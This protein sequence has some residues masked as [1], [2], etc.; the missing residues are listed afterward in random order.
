M[1]FGHGRGWRTITSERAGSSPSAD[2]APSL[3]SVQKRDHFR[4]WEG[5]NR[6][7]EFVDRG[8]CSE[9]LA[10]LRRRKSRVANVIH[11][12][13]EGLPESSDIN[14][15]DGFVMEPQ[16]PPR[17]HLKSFIK[18]S[19]TTGQYGDSVGKAKHHFLADV[20]IVHDVQ[21]RNA[22]VADFGLVEMTRNDAD[23]FAP[24]RH[25]GISEKTHQTNPAAAE[26]QS[27][28]LLSHNGAEFDSSILVDLINLNA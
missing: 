13:G 8:H 21:F 17:D 2:W 4:F 9:K 28:A 6:R 25:D 20:H 18:G 23:N 19:Q 14:D 1:G 24:T 3:D 5:A 12:V 22:L 11:E 27:H 15:H 10:R 16:L 7:Q 26:Y